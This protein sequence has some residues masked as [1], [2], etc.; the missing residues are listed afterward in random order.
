MLANLDARPHLHNYKPAGDAEPGELTLDPTTR[1]VIS[2]SIP[3]AVRDLIEAP[4]GDATCGPHMFVE[5]IGPSVATECW[6]RGVASRHAGPG[7]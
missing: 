6:Q 7:A 4:H 5:G 2:H 3:D 1:G